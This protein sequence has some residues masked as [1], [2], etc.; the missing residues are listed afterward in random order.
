VNDF[1]ADIWRLQAQL[2]T[3][4]LIEALGNEDPAMRRRAAAAL[5]ALTAFDAIPSLRRALE[6]EADPETRTH[7]I[8]ALDILEQEQERQSSV[9]TGTEQQED[10]PPGE[11]EALI[12][13]LKSGHPEQMIQAARELGELGNKTAVEPLVI[14]FNYPRMPIKVRLA[15]AEALLKLES[16]PIEVTL[17]GA[18]RSPEW[19]VRRNGV[20]ILGQLRAEWAVE[21]LSRAMTDEHEIVRQTAFAALQRIDTAEARNALNAAQRTGS[22][23]T[24][25]AQHED[26]IHM[27]DTAEVQRQSPEAS[28]PEVPAEKLV[29]PAKRKD[30]SDRPGK[31]PVDPTIM[32]TRPL[33]PRMVEGLP[34]F[35]E[36]STDSDDEDPD[37]TS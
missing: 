29:W 5:R 36:Y 3:Q 2:N 32:P 4:G 6:N 24:K 26:D 31:K 13:Q 27:K 12:A 15:A 7:I 8:A 14:L 16:A 35:E 18:L 1:K 9:E 19:R 11:I 20:A 37:D 30:D 21:P 34:G 23:H 25:Q 28:L 17:L 22:Q 33:D 10:T